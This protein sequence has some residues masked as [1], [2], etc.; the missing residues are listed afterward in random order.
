MNR[1]I[2]L[3]LT[4][5]ILLTLESCNLFFHKADKKNSDLVGIIPLQDNDK[6]VYAMEARYS[7]W[8]NP[9]TLIIYIDGTRFKVSSNGKVF[10]TDGTIRFTIDNK[11][12]LDQLYFAQR[13]D[14][15]FVFY[16]DVDKTGSGSYA[17]RINVKTGKTIW[18]KQ[19]EGFSFSKPLLRG[20][21]AYIGTI[22]FIGKMKLNNGSFDWRY[23]NLGNKGRFNHFRDIDFPTSREVRFIAPHPFSMHSDTVVISDLTGEIISMN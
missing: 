21:F 4:G 14:D 22:G 19:I 12:P 1:R 11:Y 15:L 6:G 7:K 23:S 18:E 17:K 3:L 16:T 20:Q 10:N 13:Q 5:L 9:D 2:I 8:P